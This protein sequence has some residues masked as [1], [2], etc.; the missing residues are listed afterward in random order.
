[1]VHALEKTHHLL[2]PGGGV[3]D[4]HDIPAP[5]SL[6]VRVGAHSHD[7]G[8]LLDHSDFAKLRATDKALAQGV[9]VGLYTLEEESCF[10]YRIYL[11]SLDAFHQWLTGLWDTT[12]LSDDTMERLGHL[13]DDDSAE[14]T[15]IVGMASRIIRLAR[16]P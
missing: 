14:A 16:R 7:I 13:M 11:D 9:A 2:K 4:L 15:L 1:M 5:S 3:I 10:D 6:A 12:Y 8:Q